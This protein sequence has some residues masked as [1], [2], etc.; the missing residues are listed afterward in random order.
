MQSTL[1][2]AS[3]LASCPSSVC[4]AYC[5]GP[6]LWGVR[7]LGLVQQRLLPSGGLPSGGLSASLRNL[8]ALSWLYSLIFVCY[9]VCLSS[10]REILPNTL[11]QAT[12][13]C[14]YA[15]V[16]LLYLSVWP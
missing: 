15:A 16:R 2:S 5:V 10:L 1:I 8:G 12:V 7:P 14:R 4:R 9:M 3:K 6:T 11:L 13:V